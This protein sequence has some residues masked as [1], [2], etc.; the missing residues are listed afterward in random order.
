ML[1][2]CLL[3]MLL[4]LSVTDALAQRRGDGRGWRA[5]RRERMMR[6]PPRE[7]FIPRRGGD[8]MT[9]REARRAGRM[10]PARE[11]ERRV[12]PTMR[13]SQYLGFDFDGATVYTLKFLR[14]GAVIWV[15]VDARTGAV[16]G[17]T[18]R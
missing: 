1:R 12:V 6:R 9:L 4:A 17:R 3:V 2:V 10:M 7:V 5:E 14:D 11:I 15:D 18:G 8:A 16:L 13:G